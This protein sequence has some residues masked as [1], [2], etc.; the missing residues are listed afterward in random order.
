M[1][2]HF[3]Y[4]RANKQLQHQFS[5]PFYKQQQVP[6]HLPPLEH[7]AQVQDDSRLPLRGRRLGGQRH[8]LLPVGL[9]QQGEKKKGD[10]WERNPKAFLTS[11]SGKTAF[12]YK[13]KCNII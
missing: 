11:Y 2:E 6:G 10:P 4:Q 9:L 13:N 3:S 12:M 1:K 8:I 5:S 7:P